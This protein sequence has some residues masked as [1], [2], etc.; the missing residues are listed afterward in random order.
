MCLIIWHLLHF[1]VLH[2]RVC[3]LQTEGKTLHQQRL[4][5]TYC[6]GLETNPHLWGMYACVRFLPTEFP[7][8]EAYRFFVVLK[9]A[10][11]SCPSLTLRLLPPPP[12]PTSLTLLPIFS[13]FY[14]FIPRR[15]REN[16][17]G[18]QGRTKSF[19]GRKNNALP[20]Y[21]MLMLPLP[22]PLNM[23]ALHVKQ[24]KYE[25][26]RI[27]QYTIVKMLETAQ[28]ALIIFFSFCWRVKFSL[29]A[30][31]PMSCVPFKKHIWSK[32]LY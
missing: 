17:G 21:H 8:S 27:S 25:P 31:I 4:Q 6:R 29:T 13:S 18:A 7:K 20:F 9:M 12:E 10:P 24:E 3:S 26:I 28:K 30:M 5:I 19:L 16:T 23:E 2:R 22:H 32:A 1:I 15:P 14:C 11:L